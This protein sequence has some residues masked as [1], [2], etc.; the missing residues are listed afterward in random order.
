MKNQ[1]IVQAEFE[2]LSE[3]FNAAE[4]GSFST[5]TSN[6]IQERSRVERECCSQDE[7]VCA[8]RAQTP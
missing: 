2:K 1:K 8:D 3:F 4:R 5:A 6:M 7:R